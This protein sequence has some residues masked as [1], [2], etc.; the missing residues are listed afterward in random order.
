MSF[1]DKFAWGAAAAS[2]QI[3]GAAWDDGKGL[4]VW[5]MM[6]RQKGKIWAGNTGDVACDHY[7]RYEEDCRIMAGIGLK[8]ISCGQSWTISSGAT[9]TSNVSGWF[10]L[11][12]P[13]AGA[14]SRTPPTG[15]RMSSPASARTS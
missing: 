15:I 5:D 9:A 14:L 4:S 3:E 8:A 2:Y 10:M 12:I 13:A 11:T 1:P 6:C 7:H